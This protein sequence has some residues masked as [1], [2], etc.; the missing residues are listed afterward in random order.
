MMSRFAKR[1]MRNAADIEE[2]GAHIIVV[3]LQKVIAV[4]EAVEFHLHMHF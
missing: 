1:F 2:S 4:E 3:S